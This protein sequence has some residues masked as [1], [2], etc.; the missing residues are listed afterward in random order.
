MADVVIRVRD[1]GPY[2][3]EGPVT[4]L[5]AAGNTFPIDKTKSAVALCRCGASGRKP[6]CDGS[7]NTCGFR[8][9][10]RALSTG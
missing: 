3:I 8:A 5:D 10:D 4:V 6:F 9:A 7:H 1:H 2:L